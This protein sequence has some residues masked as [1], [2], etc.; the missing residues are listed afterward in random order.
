MSLLHFKGQTREEDGDGYPGRVKRQFFLH[1]TRV[2][3]FPHH[4][5][6]HPLLLVNPA[7]PLTIAGNNLNNIAPALPAHTLDP[8]VRPWSAFIRLPISQIRL[9][10]VFTGGAS[11]RRT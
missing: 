8:V 2:A 11:T 5:L 6:L 3:L 10:A 7:A 4:V 1:R 9:K